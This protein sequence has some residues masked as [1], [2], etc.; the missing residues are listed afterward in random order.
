MLEDAVELLRPYMTGKANTRP[1]IEGLLP[2][3]DYTKP[4]PWRALDEAEAEEDA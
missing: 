1:P 2:E 4:W 3:V